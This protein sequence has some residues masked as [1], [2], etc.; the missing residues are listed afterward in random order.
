M[1]SIDGPKRQLICCRCRIAIPDSTLITEE[2]YQS[3]LCAACYV[4]DSLATNHLP[5]SKENQL[6]LFRL[7]SSER[8]TLHSE[9]VA[10]PEEIKRRRLAEDERT[11]N[12]H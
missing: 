3:R 12:Q 6:P 2:M 1:K 5:E 9:D 8:L 11:R 4:V 10:D 7:V